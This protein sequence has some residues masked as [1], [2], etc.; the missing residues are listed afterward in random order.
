MPTGRRGK[1]ADLYN[2]FEI[3]DEAPQVQESEFYSADLQ[4]PLRTFYTVP[5]GHDFTG[6][7][8]EPS[9][10]F[11]I[12]YPTITPSRLEF[13]GDDAIPAWQ[14]SFLMPI[15]KTGALFRV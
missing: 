14:G 1:A 13:Y 11:F 7:A 4:P 6:E 9:G 3:P 2:A 12:C 8:C 5:T 10:F 15:L